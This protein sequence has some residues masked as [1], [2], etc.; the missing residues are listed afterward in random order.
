M[1]KKLINLPGILF[2][3]L[4]SNSIN[5]FP[6]KTEGEAIKLLDSIHS[7]LSLYYGS[8]T[9]EYP[10]QIMSAMFIEENDRV[11]ELGGNIG[12]NSCVISSILNDSKNLVVVESDPATANLLRTNKLLNNF[13]FGIED[14]AISKVPLVQSG[15]STFP[16]DQDLPNFFRIKTIDYN[17][18][19]KKYNIPFNV[20][21]VDCEGALY[22]ILHDYD[23]FLDGIEKIIIENDYPDRAHFDYVCSKFIAKGFKLVYNKP[24]METPLPCRN[25]FY[26]VWVSNKLI[27]N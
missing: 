20:L 10:E 1:K 7:K 21:V 24:L 15:W 12:R 18:F 25:E 2:L 22:H 23:N 16:S 9:E 13:L 27:M 6:I 26:Q 14:S 19:C 3:C 17:E 8:L 5:S 4:V 11:L